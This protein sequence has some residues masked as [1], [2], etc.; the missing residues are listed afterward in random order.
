LATADRERREW[1]HDQQGCH[2]VRESQ[3]RAL[4]NGLHAHRS[5]PHGSRHAG[6]I[7]IWLSPGDDR[8]ILMVS[9]LPVRIID[10]IWILRIG[11][12]IEH[13]R[14]VEVSLTPRTARIR[15][16]QVAFATQAMMS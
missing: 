6:A 14:R 7:Q 3:R 4:P 13:L 10:R 11:S 5:I 15:H 9:A 8:K 2:S 1:R 12:S 16:P